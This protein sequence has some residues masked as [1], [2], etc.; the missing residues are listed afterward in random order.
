[1]VCLYDRR[2]Q[3]SQDPVFS[4]AVSLEKCQRSRF[5]IYECVSTGESKHRIKTLALEKLPRQK[6]AVY[7]P[8]ITAYIPNPRK[9]SDNPSP[10][11]TKFPS[12]LHSPFSLHQRAILHPA[13]TH[14]KPTPTALVRCKTRRRRARRGQAP[15][16]LRPRLGCCSYCQCV[17]RA[18]MG[19]RGLVV[20]ERREC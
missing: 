6:N 7:R 13:I 3:H 9:S 4:E 18:R 14:A 2:S 10:F 20:V 17:C 5:S 12:T 1:M 11:S 15:L 8:C 19:R 16:R